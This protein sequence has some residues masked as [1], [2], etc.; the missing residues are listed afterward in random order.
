MKGLSGVWLGQLEDLQGWRVTLSSSFNK[1]KKNP[2]CS[3]ISVSFIQNPVLN[4]RGNT[5]NIPSSGLISATCCRPCL[6]LAGLSARATISFLP[7]SD[8]GYEQAPYE[9][10]TQ[11]EY[12][13]LANSIKPINSETLKEN[14]DNYEIPEAVKY[15]TSETCQ[16]D[17]SNI[18]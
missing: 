4:S 11:E 6:H 5:N 9:E 14:L 1:K 2:I 17:L 12:E 10:I 8:H 18:N 13:A 3:A 15:C 7:L 16:V